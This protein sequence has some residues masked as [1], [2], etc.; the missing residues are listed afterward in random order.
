MSI[1][2]ELS[3]AAPGAALREPFPVE[4]IRQDFPILQETVH[5]KPLVYLDN[6]ATT[7]KPGVVIDTL[8]HYYGAE[9]AN[10]HRGVHYLSEL[11][12]RTYEEA[13]AKVR[14]FLN[15]ADTREI[16][17][18]RGTTE[19]INLVAQSYGRTF[20]KQG[21]EIVIT[22]MEHHSNIVPWQLVCEQVGARLRVVPINDDGELIVEEYARLLNERT[23]FVSVVHVSNALGTIN[24]VRQIIELAHRRGV[25]VLLDGAQ[26][27][28]HLAVDVRALDCDFY[29]FSGHKLFG[30]TGIGILY[31]KAAL[32]EAMPPYQ[33]GGD[34]ISSVTFEKT[35]Y[36]ELPY[37]FEAGTPHIAGVIGLGAAI[38]YVQAVGLEAVAAYEGELL[39]YAT[40]R[41]VALPRVRIIGTAKNKASV[42]SF[43]VEGV[44]PHDVG[45]ILDHQ[46]I[47]IRAGH[48]CAQPVMQRFGVPATNRASLA[49]YNTRADIDALVAAL[50][51]VI[52]VFG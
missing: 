11:A 45:T 44:H 50:D 52:E 51:Q 49:F 32:L 38:D 26:A 20:L 41:L 28:P 31:G 21:D 43:V 10:V 25:P 17:F 36:N 16:I 23:R 15:A 19:A 24:P 29:A 9:N 46:G 34:M 2:P 35:T 47:A 18:V 8:H 48:H 7:Q 39:A 12:T 42:L 40:E 4:R 13:R 37:K 5:G 6:A 30:P 14:A 27:A 1:A 22:A 3:R 33:G